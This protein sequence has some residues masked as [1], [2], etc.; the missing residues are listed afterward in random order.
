[1]GRDRRKQRKKG[2]VSE[3]EEERDIKFAKL[4]RKGIER[5]IQRRREPDRGGE[6]RRIGK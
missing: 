6:T 3:I 5:K 1:M 4:I 2:G